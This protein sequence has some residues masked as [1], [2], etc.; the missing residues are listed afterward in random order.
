MSAAE[1]LNSGVKIFNGCNISA[2]EA[3]DG[4][5]HAGDVISWYGEDKYICTLIHDF[6]IKLL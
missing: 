6:K 1:M 2:T 5:T 3:D 4:V